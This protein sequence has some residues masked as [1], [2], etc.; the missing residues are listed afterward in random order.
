MSRLGFVEPGSSPAV[1]MYAARELNPDFPGV[2]DLALWDVGRTLCRP[3]NPQCPQC[4]ISRM[5]VRAR[6]TASDVTARRAWCEPVALESEPPPDCLLGRPRV[7][8]HGGPL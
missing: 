1:V 6:T 3:V 7:S 2:F 4:R 8:Q 5:H